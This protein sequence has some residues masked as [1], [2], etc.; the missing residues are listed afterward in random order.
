MNTTLPATMLTMLL[1]VSTTFAQQAP[2][3]APE[4]PPL[5]KAVSSL[6]AITSGGYLYVYGG[7]AGKTHSYDTDGVLGTFHRLK[8]D[9]GTKWEELAKGPILQ[10]MNLVTHGGKIY[11]IGGMQPRNAPGEPTDNHS[12]STCSRF[13]P[14]TGK[15]EDIAPL[16]AARSSHDVVAVGDKL[17]VVGGW[18]MNG[19]GAKSTWPD[20]AY[21]LNLA[22]KEL[23]W[24]TVPQPFKRRGVAAAAVGTKVYVM[25]G[26]GEEG[27]V[28]SVEV[29]DLASGK[30]T[31]GPLLPGTDHAAFSPAA[32]VVNGKIVV[33]TSA[34]TI[35]RMNDAANGW[36]KVGEAKK[37]RMVA[38]L[39][40]LG[41]DGVIILGGAGG[42]GNIDAVEFVR[43]AARGEPVASDK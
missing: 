18:Q 17:M 5:P 27:A 16:P 22:A 26:M 11:R 31:A 7:H 24:E 2:I 23:K 39:V 4:F 30:W 1:I 10:G 13:D 15:W 3:K 9:G 8:L 38:R 37:K 20:T 43:L 19:K 35:F 14:V 6:G 28:R 40:S 29:L 12:V 21:I 41:D 42:D 25:G 34:G 33:N 36:E 32:G